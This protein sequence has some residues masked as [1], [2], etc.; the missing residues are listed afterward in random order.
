MAQNFKYIFYGEGGGGG[1][2]EKWYGGV[3]RFCLY[4]GEGENKIGLVLGGGGG[5]IS[6]QF[7]VL[8]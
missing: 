3:W 8:S 5:V 6:M 7:L 4:F 2:S 1:G